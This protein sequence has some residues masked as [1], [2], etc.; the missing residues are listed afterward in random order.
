[1]RALQI[2]PSFAASPWQLVDRPTPVLRD[3]DV[4]LDVVAAGVN[5]ADL[6]QCRGLYPPPP[7]ESDIPGLEVSG[8]IALLTPGA[9][10]RADALGLSH[11]CL[12]A[13]VMALLA[14]GG[15]ATQVAVPVEQVLPIP[16]G[17]SL[18]DAAGIP[19]VFLTAYLNLFLLAGLSFPGR[20]QQVAS[21]VSTPAS[22]LV[23]GGASGVGTAALQLLKLAGHLAYCTVGEDAR[24][25]PC[26]QLG[27]HA[28]LNYRTRAPDSEK[29]LWPTTLHKLVP[30]GVAVVL[31]CVGG[32]Y[33][34]HNLD[35]L[36]P[37]GR[38]VL[39]GLQ[40][41][42]R[43]ELDLALLLRR[44]LQIIGSTLRALPPPRKAALCRDAAQ[45]VL[46]HFASGALA[47]VIHRVY[48]LSEAHQAH[49]ALDGSHV[50][51][52]LLAVR[53]AC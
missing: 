26:L 28:A 16:S 40:G 11:V 32:S 3:G 10:A 46:P 7:G 4:L 21:A 18:L 48:P 36:A 5:R 15:Y 38:L 44:R 9:L 27:A 2:E 17:V 34:A 19:E 53:D 47:P 8:H 35:L 50:G 42:A 25:G 41:G 45:H 22:V 30:G 33:L 43:A 13:P 12:G 14:G 20:P 37:D 39:I 23:H 6:M 29:P 51:K 49:A 1:M 31:D 52:V 24:T